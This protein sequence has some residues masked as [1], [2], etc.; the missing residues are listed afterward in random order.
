MDTIT[1]KDFSSRFANLLLSCSGVLPGKPR[2]RELLYASAVLELEPGRE[3]AEGQ[4]N[5]HLLAWTQAFGAHFALDPITLRRELVDTGYLA[6]DRAGRP[7]IHQP[8]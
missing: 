3:Y 2:D 5:G 8:I 6:R 1:T 7:G 4:V